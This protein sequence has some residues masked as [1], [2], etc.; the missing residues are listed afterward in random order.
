MAEGNEFVLRLLTERR[1]RLVGSI[2]SEAERNLFPHAPAPVR[3]AFRQKVLEYVGAYH[4]VALDCMK[5]SVDD[6]T[7]NDPT[8]LLQAIR[9][10]VRTTMRSELAKGEH[11]G[12]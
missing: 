4:D 11:D 10:E 3:A 7:R 1:Q 5:A 9:S 6:G 8:L 12:G 2:M